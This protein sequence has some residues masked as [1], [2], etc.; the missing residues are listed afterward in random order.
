MSEVS[1]LY[2]LAQLVPAIVIVLCDGRWPL[3]IPGLDAVSSTS[4]GS[5][6]RLI[7]LVQ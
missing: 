7:C 6:E 5:V 4:L 2:L 1:D 3:A